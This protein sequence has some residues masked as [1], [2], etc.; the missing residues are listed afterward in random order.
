MIIGISGK[1]QSGKDLIGQIIDYLIWKNST[2]TELYRLFKEDGFTITLDDYIKQNGKQF[3]IW[4]IRK[5]AEPLKQICAILLGV[6]V[7]KF[8]DEEF[9]NSELGEEW[10]TLKY[11]CHCLDVTPLSKTHECNYCGILPTEVPMTPRMLLQKVGTDA[12][13]DNVHTN[14]W[15]N[16]LFANYED[17]KQWIITDVRF[18]NE[19]NAI[20]NRSGINI[21]VDRDLHKGNAHIAPIPHISE[22]DLDNT[23]FDYYIDNNGT[24]EELIEKVREF[25]ILQG[26]LNS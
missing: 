1:K 12:I 19:F 25:L 5:F 23:V 3:S 18:K 14:T 16:A 10:N 15:V 6:P 7:E 24:V 26:L 17:Y 9:K 11:S 8:E 20:K 2:H 13:R 4:K 22:T 21:R